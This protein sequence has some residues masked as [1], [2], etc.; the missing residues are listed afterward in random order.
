MSNLRSYIQFNFCKSEHGRKYS[1]PRNVDS[2]I[3]DGEIVG[4]WRQDNFRS[5]W[6]RWFKQCLMIMQTNHD[7]LFEFAK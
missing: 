4:F 6:K 2:E 3:A 5:H 7:K 1:P